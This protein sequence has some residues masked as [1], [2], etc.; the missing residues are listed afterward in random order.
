VSEHAPEI[1]SEEVASEVE[2]TAETAT[3]ASAEPNANANEK[4]ETP[5]LDVHMPHATHT[6]KDF[7]IHL[8][9][10]TA[11]LLIAFALLMVGTD[12]AQAPVPPGGAWPVWA[13]PV[14]AASPLVVGD[15][16]ASSD[17]PVEHVAGSAAGYTKTQIANLFVAVDWFPGS[18]PVMPAVV[19]TGRRPAVYACAH[20]HQPSGLGR[21]ENQSLAGLSAAYMEQQMVDFKNDLRRSSEPRMGP[22]SRMVLVAKAATAEEIRVASEYFAGLKP[23]KWIRVVETDTAPVTRPQG[24]MLVADSGGATEPIGERVIEVSED[25]A[26]SELRNPTSGFVA[27]VPNGS[28]KAGESLVKTGGKAGMLPCTVCH[29]QDLKGQSMK[30]MGDV[31]PIA[32]RS[33]SQMARQLIDFRSGARHGV[34]SAAMKALA[35]ELSDADVVAITG[36]LASLNP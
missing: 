32:G 22:Q 18:H 2:E 11:G 9:T 24:W 1:P 29:G 12:T 4:E 26:Q 30:G 6:W 7:F 33:P 17:E 14:S 8:G 28:L 19:A 23:R 15:A 16:A 25:F 31:P 27:Y 10:I 20:C 21:P 3:P 13:Y 34:N 5:V 36:Y 35:S